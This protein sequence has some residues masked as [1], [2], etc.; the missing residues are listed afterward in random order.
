MKK[1]LLTGGNG[2]FCTR[3]KKKYENNFEILSYGK[4][5]LDIV[6]EKQVQTIFKEFKPDYVVHAAAIAVT[7][8][9]NNHPEL[10][11]K[12]N[13]ECIKEFHLK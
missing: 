10:A 2:F 6:N 5:K 8:F 3:L 4:D 12:I 9:C 11:H 7:D 1:I 13:V